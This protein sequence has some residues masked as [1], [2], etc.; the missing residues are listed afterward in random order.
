MADPKPFSAES[1]ATL[2]AL[3]DYITELHEEWKILL[4]LFAAGDETSKL[5]NDTAGALFETLYR[6]LIRDILLGV[7]RLTD[8]LKTAGKDN[9]VLERVTLLPEVV[10]DTALSRAAA[11]ILDEIKALATPFRDYRNKY[12]AHLDLPTS[13]SPSG[14]VLPGIKRQDVDAVVTAFAKLFNRV[15]GPL[16]DRHVVFKDVT[17]FGGPNSLLRACDD[18]RTWRSVPASE[19]R[20]IVE[21]GDRG[22]DG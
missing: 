21:R 16:R 2:D 20:K 3:E 13:L 17:I 10:A 15:D 1:A 12:L 7:A 5:L 18:A 19:R 22:G 4:E 11:E 14:D 6:V 8:P 9:L